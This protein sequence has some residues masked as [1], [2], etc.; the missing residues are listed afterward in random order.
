MYKNRLTPF[1][2]I[3]VSLLLT[4]CSGGSQTSTE[5][6]DF[7]E[8][9]D[10]PLVQS[11][12]SI[13]GMWRTTQEIGDILADEVD[14]PNEYVQ[15]IAD[16][17]FNFSSDLDSK[18]YFTLNDLESG[19]PIDCFYIL[20]LEIDHIGEDVFILNGELVSFTRL[21]TDL[22]SNLPDKSFNLQ[23]STLTAEEIENNE[24]DI[25]LFGKIT[26]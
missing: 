24:C 12:D 1:F 3:L 19:S 10:K 15:V 17:F 6:I 22:T 14:L 25:D 7:D 5:D 20:P 23:L 16:I 13:E 4:A 8:L 18:I 11:L 2:F 21:D 9:D 26:F